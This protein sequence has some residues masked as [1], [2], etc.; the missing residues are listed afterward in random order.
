MSD[1]TVDDIPD[2][3]D[4]VALITGANSGIG[5]E[6]AVALAAKGAHVVMACRN[7]DKATAAM[8]DLTARVPGASVEFL[9]L[10]LAD[11]DSIQTAADTVGQ[12][13]DRLDLLINNAGIMAPPEQRT[14]QGFEM[15]FGVNHLGHFA[16]D[17]L[18]LDLVHGTAG[19]R[20]VT[21]SSFGHKPGKIDFDDLN[22]EKRYS[23]WL[24][25]FQSKLAN[26]LFM[27]ELQRRLTAAG[28]DTIS[29]A[30]HPGASNTNL[31]HE[32]SDGIL[33]SIFQA[34]E[35]VVKRFLSQSAEMGALPTLR[36]ATDPGTIGGDYYGPG[37]IGE[38]R[39]HPVLVD[40]SGRARNA[41]DGVRLWNESVGLTGVSYEI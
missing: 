25:Y 34:A 35:P 4:R 33:G 8:S 12:I 26:L 1:W 15:Q 30:A 32:A 36:A 5:Y 21:V 23:A 9:E 31:G 38:Q 16:L 17:G 18:L 2:Q 6:A 14:A 13:H 37:G 41:A 3:T 24:G 11:L 39:G 29:V 40:M 27:R 28:S 19:S 7:E 10:D 22:S 20:V